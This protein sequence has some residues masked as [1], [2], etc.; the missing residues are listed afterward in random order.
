MTTKNCEN[1]VCK[2]PTPDVE[3]VEEP[4]IVIE[5]GLRM[6]SYQIGNKIKEAI[7]LLEFDV[8]IDNIR[9]V[10]HRRP[11]APETEDEEDDD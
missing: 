6:D 4:L 11:E 5:N 9:V 1:W 7:K 3:V 8:I 10:P 2:E